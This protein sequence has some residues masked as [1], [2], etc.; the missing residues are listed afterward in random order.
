LAA[1]DLLLDGIT[2]RIARRRAVAAARG[3]R[4]DEEPNREMAYALLRQAD[5]EE[6]TVM[7]EHDLERP[8][9]TPIGARPWDALRLA[10]DD[11]DDDD[12]DEPSAPPLPLDEPTPPPVIDPPAEP[13]P[14]GPMTV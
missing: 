1:S 7:V 2:N 9:S 11:D 5:T 4:L 8:S 13:T 3:R 14:R 12:G 6:V 10:D